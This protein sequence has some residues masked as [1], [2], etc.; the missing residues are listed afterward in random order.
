MDMNEEQTKELLKMIMSVPDKELRTQMLVMH[1][2]YQ[3]MTVA[4]LIMSCFRL[5]KT[6]NEMLGF[7]EDILVGVGKQVC[8]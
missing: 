7:N 4:E 2:I 5:G 1:L 3:E 6:P 8:S